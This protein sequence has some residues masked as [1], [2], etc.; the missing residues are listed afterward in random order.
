[1]RNTGG[2]IGALWNEPSAGHN[3]AGTIIEEKKPIQLFGSR[4]YIKDNHSDWNQDGHSNCFLNLKKI[5]SPVK[6]E[7]I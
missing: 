1:M 4:H 5:L 7:R 6:G 2:V 3:V